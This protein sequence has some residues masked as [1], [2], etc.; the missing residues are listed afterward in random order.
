VEFW[1]E[2]QAEGAESSG[3]LGGVSGSNP[4]RIEVS[5]KTI[6]IVSSGVCPQSHRGLGMDELTSDYNFV[7]S[8]GNWIS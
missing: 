1:I 2:A 7:A 8:S 6:S 3:T 4:V 5:M